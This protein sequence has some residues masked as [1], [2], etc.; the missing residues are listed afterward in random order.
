MA[1]LEFNFLF[2]KCIYDDINK[3]LA[4]VRTLM[5]LI[6]KLKRLAKKKCAKIGIGVDDSQTTSKLIDNSISSASKNGYADV[7]VFNSPQ[8]LI[9]ALK[10]GELDG[11]IRGSLEAKETMAELK[12]VFNLVS[13]FR[14]AYI[15]LDKKSC[16]FLAPVGID[17]GIFI[18]ERLQFI[19]LIDALH[20]RLGVTSKTAI[21]S[22]G[23][24]DDLG[25]SGLVD[26]SLHAGE[27]LFNLANETGIN[28]KHYGILIEEAYKNSNIIIAPNGI[29]GNLLFRTL[30]L[31]SNFRSFGA[32]ILNLDKTFIDTS[33]SRQDYTDPIMLASALSKLRD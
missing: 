26:E 25:R 31:M 27:K 22:G 18:D 10:T 11:V 33:R 6:Q 14:A 15:C 13:I 24:L 19:K 32:P 2:F 29:V 20:Q 30:H 3:Y 17:E 16:F 4:V 21:I 23:R 7:E 1:N 12:K 28:V 5:D 8:E 9:Y